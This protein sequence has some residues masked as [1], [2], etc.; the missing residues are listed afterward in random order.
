MTTKRK[1]KPARPRRRTVLLVWRM[2]KGRP[3]FRCLYS[4]EWAGAIVGVPS[5]TGWQATPLATEQR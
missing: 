1:P 4:P 3:E 2:R 5:P